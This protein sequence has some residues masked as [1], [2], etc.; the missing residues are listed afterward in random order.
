MVKRHMKR[1]PHMTLCMIKFEKQPT[2]WCSNLLPPL[3][4]PHLVRNE[5][6]EKRREPVCHPLVPRL[7]Q[8][9]LLRELWFVIRKKYQ[10]HMLSAK[11]LYSAHARANFVARGEKKKCHKGIGYCP[12]TNRHVVVVIVIQT[13]DV[14]EPRIDVLEQ[15][16]AEEHVEDDGD[17][18]AAIPDRK[19]KKEDG[20]HRRR[21]R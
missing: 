1:A 14:H 12:T 18:I 5:R 9:W 13:R 2:G 10:P 19:K 16:H 11:K 17:E 8:P 21:K 4:L 15:N 7:A 3:P 20:N 6:D